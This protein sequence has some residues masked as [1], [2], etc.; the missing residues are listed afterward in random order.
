MLRTFSINSSFKNQ[1]L[2]QNWR[3]HVL[4]FQKL[5]LEISMI[6]IIP[7]CPLVILY[8]VSIGFFSNIIDSHLSVCGCVCGYVYL[9]KPKDIFICCL[10]SRR[11]DFYHFILCFLF[12]Y[13]FLCYN[14]ILSRP[15]YATDLC[16]MWNKRGYIFNNSE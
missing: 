1:F 2:I 15:E 13:F 10:S 5:L 16:E 4:N 14:F 6:R 7:I 8:F 11:C 12:V 9:Y 3:I